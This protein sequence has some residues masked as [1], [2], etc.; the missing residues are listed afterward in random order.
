[1]TDAR[2]SPE[3]GAVGQEPQQPAAAGSSRMP[4]PDER[5]RIFE[6]VEKVL[7]WVR[8]TRAARLAP[9]RFLTPIDYLINLNIAVPQPPTGASRL[10][11][12]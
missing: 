1:M 10:P 7:Y 9:D 3:E 12:G 4:A 6:R 8:R 11:V 2:D 5:D